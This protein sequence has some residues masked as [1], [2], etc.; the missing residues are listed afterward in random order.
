MILPIEAG[1]G[2][3]CDGQR[4]SCGKQLATHTT[5]HQAR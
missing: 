4:L 2:G 5:H 3:G 1:W